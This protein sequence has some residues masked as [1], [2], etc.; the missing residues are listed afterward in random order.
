MDPTGQGLSYSLTDRGVIG[1]RADDPLADYDILR[2]QSRIFFNIA[3]VLKLKRFKYRYTH[4]KTRKRD[5]KSETDK[6]KALRHLYNVNDNLIKKA[7]QRNRLSTPAGDFTAEK[8]EDKNFLEL[9]VGTEYD[10]YEARLRKENRNLWLDVP[11]QSPWQDLEMR[12]KLDAGIIKGKS[13]FKYDFFGDR[14]RQHNHSLGLYLP[15]NTSVLASYEF[16]RDRSIALNRQSSVPSDI[17]QWSIAFATDWVP[18]FQFKSHYS[19]RLVEQKELTAGLSQPNLDDTYESQFSLAYFP[20]SNCWGLRAV[21]TKPFDREEENAD[22]HLEFI[23]KFGPYSRSLP[24][25]SGAVE[26]WIPG[27]IQEL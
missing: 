11:V 6:E 23:L 9:D 27:G 10:F 1:E 25:M 18:L 13:S 14:L 12:F 16:Y 17:K 21:R 2:R 5:R 7:K 8:T 15:R 26:K 24:D 19:K 22:Y 3:Q 4:D 20:S